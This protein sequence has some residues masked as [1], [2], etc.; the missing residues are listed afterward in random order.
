MKNKE[1]KRSL[2]QVIVNLKLK[3]NFESEDATVFSRIKILP[4]DVY[5]DATTE[6]TIVNEETANEVKPKKKKKINK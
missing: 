2:K 6:N 3:K 5:E 1:T 4:Q